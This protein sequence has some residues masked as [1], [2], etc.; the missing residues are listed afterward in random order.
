VPDADERF[1][2]QQEYLDPTTA[3]SRRRE[4]EA[5]Y[6]VDFALLRPRDEREQALLAILVDEGAT[7]IHEDARYALVAL[8]GVADTY[9]ASP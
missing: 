1:A 7:V 8:A 9:A 4:I 2:A 5:R 6:D 3:P